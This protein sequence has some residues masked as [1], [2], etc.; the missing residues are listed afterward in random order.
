MLHYSRGMLSNN[1][2]VSTPVGESVIVRTVYR[3]CTIQINM[4]EFPADLIVFPLLEQDIILGMDWLSR[5][6]ALV[7]CYTKEMV[8]DRPGMDK[9]VFY[10]ERKAVPSCLV[11]AVT[12]FRLINEGCQAYLAHVVDSTPEVKELNDVQVVKEFPDAFPEDLPGML[13][14]RETEFTI[15]VAP[16]VAPISIPPYWMAPLELQELKK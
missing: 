16:R 8:F 2:I 3:D 11:S 5:H 14:D 1:L 7:N 6:R 4:V 15:E 13:P 12:V 10:G 9:V